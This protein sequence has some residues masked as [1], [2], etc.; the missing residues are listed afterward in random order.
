MKIIDNKA[1]DYIS[2]LFNKYIV[3]IAI[4]V[5]FAFGG[6]VYTTIQ[7]VV[8]GPKEIKYL[9]SIHTQDSI[10]AQNYTIMNNRRFDSIAKIV[11]NHTAWIDQDFNDLTKIKKKLKIQ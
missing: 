11:S 1:K 2:G 7:L 3:G 8:N 9:K 6:T 5:S 10:R 4:A